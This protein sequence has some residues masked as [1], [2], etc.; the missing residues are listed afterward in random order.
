MNRRLMILRSFFL[1]RLSRLSAFIERPMKIE[2]VVDL[3]K[4]LPL[5]SRVAPAPA[6]NNGVQTPTPR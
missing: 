6:D 2:I 4:P 1:L 5:A 3:S